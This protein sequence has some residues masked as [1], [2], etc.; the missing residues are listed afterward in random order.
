MILT[1]H[2]L[3]QAQTLLAK[4]NRLAHIQRTLLVYMI[5]TAM[6]G[7]GAKTRMEIILPYGYFAEV[8]GQK[9]P[10]F[11]DRPNA[12]MPKPTTGNGTNPGVNGNVGF[13]IVVL[14]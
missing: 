5:C 7:S 11:A 10:G 13:R 8:V 9:V 2:A 3:I 1:I 4:L 14:L 12:L 6:R